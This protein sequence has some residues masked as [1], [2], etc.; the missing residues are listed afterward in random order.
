MQN[1]IHA[2]DESFKIRPETKSAQQITGRPDPDQQTRES[3]RLQLAELAAERAALKSPFG[4]SSFSD[5]TRMI[6][7][8]EAQLKDCYGGQ[9]MDYNNGSAS[10]ATA[11]GG[12][13]LEAFLSEIR[14]DSL[15][16]ALAMIQSLQ[17]QLHVLYTEGET[18]AAEQSLCSMYEEK[19]AF[20]NRFGFSGV[21]ETA[22]MI[23]SMESQLRDFYSYPA[24]AA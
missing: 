20:H 17:E 11:S 9:A 18:R 12:I 3:I 14:C 10:N 1:Q 21:E 16:Q 22:L 2:L 13:R 23:S 4:C 5:V 6:D 8:L 24:L 15:D 7:S 19:E